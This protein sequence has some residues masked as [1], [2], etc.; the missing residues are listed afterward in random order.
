MFPISNK[1]HESVFTFCDVANVGRS[2]GPGKSAVEFFSRSDGRR[3][4]TYWLHAPE[5]LHPLQL[6]QP[7][8]LVLPQLCSGTLHRYKRWRSPSGSARFCPPRPLVT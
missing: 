4:G 2:F 3:L 8:S 1:R 5:P 6:R 7:E